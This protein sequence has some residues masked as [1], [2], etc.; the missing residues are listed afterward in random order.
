MSHLLF[1]SDR[2]CCAETISDIESGSFSIE[3][4][5]RWELMFA[6]TILNRINNSTEYPMC[7]RKVPGENGFA[8]ELSSRNSQQQSISRLQMYGQP[9]VAP[10]WHLPLHLLNYPCPNGAT[11]LYV[12]TIAR[13]ISLTPWPRFLYHCC[14][15]DSFLNVTKESVFQPGSECV[16]LICTLRRIQ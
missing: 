9:N 11:A 8:A 7:S 5:P 15:V 10:N 1:V 16:D 2:L 3:P 14:I 4:C 6:I 12:E 13:F